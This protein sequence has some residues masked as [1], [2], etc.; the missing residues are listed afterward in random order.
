MKGGLVGRL[1][2]DEPNAHVVTLRERT[3]EVYVPK[4]NTVQVYD[5]GK[6]GQQFDQFLLIGFGTSGKDLQKNYTI[7]LIANDAIGDRKTTH[8]ELVPKTKEALNYF[9]TAEWWM[10][11]D[12]TYPVQAKIHRNSQDYILINYSDVKLN[13][14]LTDNELEVKLP[15][16]VQKIYPNNSLAAAMI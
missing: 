13:A 12:A 11:Q 10:A 16:D 4:S 3:V 2:F 14:P 9:K 6:F 1:D 7:R 15:K 5:V 8:I